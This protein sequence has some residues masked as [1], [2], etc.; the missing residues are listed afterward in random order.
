[1]NF[2]FHKMQGISGVDKEVLPKKNSAPGV[3]FVGLL[4]S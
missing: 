4:G 1:M 2:G 3:W